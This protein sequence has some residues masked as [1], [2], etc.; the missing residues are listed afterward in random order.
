MPEHD[1]LL[2]DEERAA[3]EAEEGE[4]IDG[5]AALEQDMEEWKASGWKEEGMAAAPE[6]EGEGEG[7]DDDPDAAQAEGEE[8]Q[9]PD[10]EPEPE[11]EPQQQQK[12]PEPRINTAELDQTIADLRKQDDAYLDQ[13][14]D[15]DLTRE[16][17]AEKRA[18]LQKQ[19]DNAT[20]QKAIAADR[21]E[22]EL[23]QWK[24]SVNSYFKEYPG[25]KDD[26][27]IEAFDAEVRAV[28]GSRAYAN[29]SYDQ[30]LKLAHKRLAAS[31]ED[32]GI[33]V[34]EL[35]GAKKADPKP[36]KEQKSDPKGDDMR[37]PPKTLAKVPASDVT[38]S[39]DGQYAALE[40]IMQYGT[41]DEVEEA[42][43]K[44]SPEERDRYASANT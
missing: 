33:E 6:E 15:G 38:G 25:L 13:Y 9:K 27:V 3:I 23:E 12:A 40:R 19:I 5:S 39:N 17:L 7:D 43:A 2:T 24:G 18:E 26:K 28:T 32:I 8:G 21:A 42:L 41:P 11:P 34:P 4:E 16:E 36:Q 37:T 14:D 31:A 44:M 30:Q 1:D 22:R 35:K 10:P 20:A 29:L